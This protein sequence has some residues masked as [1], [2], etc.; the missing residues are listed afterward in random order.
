MKS[1]GVE[2]DLKRVFPEECSVGV[3]SAFSAEIPVFAVAE[4][5]AEFSAGAIFSGTSLIDDQFSPALFRTVECCDCCICLFCIGHF[6]EPESS[7]TVRFAVDCEICFFDGSEAFEE[8]LQFFSRHCIRHVSDINFHKAFPDP[9]VVFTDPLVTPSFFFFPAAA[10]IFS[11]S[12]DPQR[13][14]DLNRRERGFRL[15]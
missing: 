7:G 3:F 13:K 5:A 2:T 4:S 12:E 1:D 15:P 14:N 8:G 9:C 11:I 6:H 10:V